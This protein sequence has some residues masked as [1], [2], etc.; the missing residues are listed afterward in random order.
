MTSGEARARGWEEVT[1]AS[2][3]AALGLPVETCEGWPSPVYYA[4]EW[5]VWV[6]NEWRS[7]GI[8]GNAL[9]ACA[10][11]AKLLPDAEAHEWLRA[12]YASALLGGD[13]KAVA[14]ASDRLED[15]RAREQGRLYRELGA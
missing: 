15:M 5:A 7:D 14:L 1:A 4:P 9:R 12:A 11:V 3:Y 13:E 8:G 2:T 10:R 6:F